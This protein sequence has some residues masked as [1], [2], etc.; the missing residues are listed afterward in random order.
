MNWK[1][2]V[3]RALRWA[4]PKVVDILVREAREKVNKPQAGTWTRV[5]KE[6]K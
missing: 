3:A 2:L 5:D 6:S 4:A 1:Q